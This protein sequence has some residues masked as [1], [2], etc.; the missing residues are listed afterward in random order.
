M[1][2]VLVVAVASCHQSHAKAAPCL[3]GLQSSTAWLGSRPRR[4]SCLC[5]TER[6]QGKLI[7]DSQ[8]LAVLGGW[9][10]GRNPGSL[11][12]QAQP[13]P[14]EMN[15]TF[16][17]EVVRGAPCWRRRCR[18]GLLPEGLDVSEHRQ[19]RLQDLD[20]GLKLFPGRGVFHPAGH[21][22]AEVADLALAVIEGLVQG[23]GEVVELFHSQGVFFVCLHIQCGHEGQEIGLCRHVLAVRL[24]AHC[25]GQTLEVCTTLANLLHDAIRALLEFCL[26]RYFA[27][28]GLELQ[29]FAKG[30]KPGFGDGSAR[31]CLPLHVAKLRLDFL[32]RRHSGHVCLQEHCL[33]DC[34]QLLLAG[35]V[36]G[37][38][39]KLQGLFEHFL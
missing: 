7:L 31:R 27:G 6:A 38:C 4:Q 22:I 35:H 33:M 2:L 15:A 20:K 30:A 14:L 18:A 36:G 1:L 9:C 3:T 11:A 32:L 23:S 12:S 5:S 8:G 10:G 24:E 29:G 37:I 13:A 28:L 17:Q 21:C 34:S 16:A 39:L 19:L 26:A 25:D